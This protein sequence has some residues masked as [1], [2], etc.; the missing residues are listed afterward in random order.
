M[1]SIGQ[2]PGLAQRDVGN[3]LAGPFRQLI[4][5]ALIRQWATATGHTW[6]ETLFNPV[7]TLWACVE[8]QLAGHSARQIED[9]LAQ[10]APEHA[11]ETRDGKDFCQARA[12]L[13]LEVWPQALRHVAAQ[14]Q[15]SARWR[16][17]E[18]A[19]IDGTTA[20]MPRTPQ[21]WAY[22]GSATNQHGQGR[23]PLV[24]MS[25]LVIA[26]VI[27]AV[28]GDPYLISELAQAL[29]LLPQLPGRT[30]LLADALYG[31]YLNVGL[32]RQRDSDLLC[33]RK[34]R[35]GGTR[36]KNVG[37]GEWIER[38]DRPRGAH[39]HWPELLE[40]LPATQDLRVLIR[41][42]HRPGYRDFELVLCTTLLDPQQ[43]PA[44]ELTLLYLRRWDIE[45]DIRT[46]KLQHGLQCLTCKNPDTVLREIYAAC[47]SFNCVRC[48]MSQTNHTVRELSHTRAVALLLAGAQRMTAASPQ[49]LPRLFRELLLVIGQCRLVHQLRPPEPRQLVRIVRHY[50]LL[51][52]SRATWRAIQH[53]A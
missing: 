26:G 40:T 17:L 21:N 34:K 37:P 53:A 3:L 46:L 6:H 52:C 31:S 41:I 10:L 22:F 8:K 5:N 14:V 9:H 19:I 47:L 51:A 23:M 44:E 2:E 28:R 32:V 13:P 29:R 24:R 48:L 11:E 18:L 36:L 38:W 20:C 15:G 49:T 25:F 7:A 4:P 43:Y 45:L 27:S 39:T 42:V 16:G 50:P 30:L 33:P 1:T 35:R 12:R